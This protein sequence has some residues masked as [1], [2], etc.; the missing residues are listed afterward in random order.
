MTSELAVA[1]RVKINDSFGDPAS[2]KTGKILRK[3]VLR[4]YIEPRIPDLPRKRIDSAQAC[5]TWIVSIEK[6]GE[7]GHFFEGELEIIDEE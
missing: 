6:T 4:T 2:G 7:E 5:R 1:K 3:G